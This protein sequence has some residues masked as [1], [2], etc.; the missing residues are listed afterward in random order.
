LCL[1]PPGYFSRANA[2]DR[3]VLRALAKPAA[4]RGAQQRD[5]NQVTWEQRAMEGNPKF[6]VPLPQRH[7]AIGQP[8][9][10]TSWWVTFQAHSRSGLGSE[11]LPIS[12]TAAPKGGTLLRVDGEVVWLITRS[13]AERVPA[14]VSNIEVTR[15]S[16]DRQIS[17]RRMISAAS[18]VK[19]WA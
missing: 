16:G 15:R 4:D 6:E 17:L 8:E 9:I 19:A 2:H 1:F 3:Q 14:G 10:E 18:S 12:M 7:H 11:T 5:L 13:P